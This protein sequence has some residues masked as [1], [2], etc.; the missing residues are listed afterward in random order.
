MPKWINLLFL[1]FFTAVAGEAFFFTFIDPK[2][3]YLFGEPVDWSPMVIYSVGFFMFW[4]L[5]GLTAALVALM[6]KSGDEVNREHHPLPH[7]ARS[8]ESA[9]SA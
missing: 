4:A 5:T 9:G 2:L 6:L 7:S 3:L 1:S 8:E